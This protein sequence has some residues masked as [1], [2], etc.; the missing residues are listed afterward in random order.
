MSKGIKRSPALKFEAA[1]FNMLA[2]LGA[3]E[4]WYSELEDG[5]WGIGVNPHDEG[6][7]IKVMSEEAAMGLVY[8]M[9]LGLDTFKKKLKWEGLFLDRP[10]MPDGTPSVE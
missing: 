9:N 8:I 5:M 1:A 4:F 2:V 3:Y 7:I 6:I 10:A